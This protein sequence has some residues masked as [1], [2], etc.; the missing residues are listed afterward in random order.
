MSELSFSIQPASG[1][2]VASVTLRLTSADVAVVQQAGNPSVE[3]GGPVIAT[4]NSVP[5]TIT[6]PTNVQPL[7]DGLRVSVT[8]K[9]QPVIAENVAFAQSWVNALSSTVAAAMATRRLQATA[10]SGALSGINTI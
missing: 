1:N 6:L 7:V 10:V 9:T 8:F 4:I 3:F 2:A 5:T